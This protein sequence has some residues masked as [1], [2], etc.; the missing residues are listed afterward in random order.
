[1]SEEPKALFIEGWISDQ[2]ASGN[3]PDFGFGEPVT[4]D[5]DRFRYLSNEPGAVLPEGYCMPLE[6]KTT[7]ERIAERQQW[8]ASTE[9][10]RCCGGIG[11][12]TPSVSE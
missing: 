2:Y 9:V 1:M 3:R 8:I 10:Y 12:T 11:R 7:T 6:I 5:N 4:R